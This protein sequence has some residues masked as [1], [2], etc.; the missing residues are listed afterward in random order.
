M[1]VLA[2]GVGALVLRLLARPLGCIVAAAGRALT[3]GQ[4]RARALKALRRRLADDKHQPAFVIFSDATLR[5]MCAK[6]PATKQEM[7]SVSGVGEHKLMLYGKI[8]LE[9]ISKYR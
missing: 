8:F 4:P 6:K 2:V 1:G 7:L 5:D 9:E 3:A